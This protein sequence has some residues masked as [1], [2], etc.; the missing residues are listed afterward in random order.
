MRLITMSQLVSFFRYMK[1]E[2]SRCETE[3]FKRRPA[4]WTQ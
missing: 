4:K 2:P 1:L 3:D